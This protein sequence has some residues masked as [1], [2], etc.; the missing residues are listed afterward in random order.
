[1]FKCVPKINPHVLKRALS[2]LMRMKKS[3]NHN[4]YWRPLTDYW[5]FNLESLN[6]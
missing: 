5:M 1:M 3:M 2:H 4:K 6:I